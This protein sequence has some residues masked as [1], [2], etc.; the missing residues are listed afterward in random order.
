MRKTQ[1]KNPQKTVN[2]EKKKVKAPV[3]W[4]KTKS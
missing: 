1:Q 2:E 3:G 4:E